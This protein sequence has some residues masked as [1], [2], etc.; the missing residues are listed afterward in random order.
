MKKKMKTMIDTKY[1]SPENLEINEIA[2]SDNKV[3]KAYK[4]LESAVY[5]TLETYS[6]VHRGSGHNSKTT[7]YLFDKARDIVLEYMG[8]NKDKYVVIFCTLRRAEILKVKLASNDYQILSSQD[9]GLPIGVRA[10]AV[11][12]NKLPKGIPF[13]TGGGTAKLMSQNWVIWSGS[14]DKFEAGTPAIINIIMFA[15]ALLLIQEY[16][17]YIFADS[18]F[19]KCSATELFYNDELE[20][21]SGMELLHELRK[22]LIGRTILVPTTEGSNLFVNF[23]NAAS[24]PTFEPIWNVFHQTW[25]QPIKVQQDIINEVKIICSE[26]LGAPLSDYDVIFTSNTTE[27]INLSAESLEREFAE[28][29]EGVIVNTFLEHSSNDLPWRMIPKHSLIRLKVNDE[30]FIDLNELETLLRSYNL[31]ELYG[32]KRIRLVA[33]SS[34]S[35][36]LGVCNNLNEISQIVHRY[37]ARLLVDAAQLVAHR[38]IDIELCQIDYLACSAHKVYAP[39]GC[40][41]LV[42]RKGLLNFKPDVLESIKSSGEEN[43]GGIAALGKSLVLLK[44]IGMDLIQKEEQNLTKRVLH[45]M[46]E[47]E[48]IKIYGIKNQESPDFANKLGV[49]VFHIGGKMPARIA[50]ELALIGGIGIRF[51][52]HCSHIMVK[53]ILNVSPF[54]ERFQWFIQTL[55]PG[56]RFP[57][58]ARVS[59]GI[60]NTEED[61]DRLIQTLGKIAQKTQTRMDNNIASKYNKTPILSQTEVKQHIREFVM[62]AAHKVYSQI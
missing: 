45:G 33:I 22:T 15:K 36:V 52:C 30:G 44:R 17:E 13:Q 10:L 5:A 51:G 39:F 60:E 42:V 31:E 32:K 20:K 16:G 57:G 35:N 14:P 61:V 29:S 24:T 56:V 48:G 43:A 49:I 37:G 27:A 23:D 9:I 12:K 53:R 8:L 21:Y 19:E 28:D 34:A 3:A 40:G 26:F 25:H 47:V 46:K 6:N 4:E 18:P 2:L 11:K 7:T 55:I 41:V 62:A 59:L 38:K 50:R 54:L 58:V 1:E